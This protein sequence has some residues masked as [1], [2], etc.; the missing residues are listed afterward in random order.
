MKKFTQKLGKR[1]TA[2][3]LVLLM[4]ASSG[5]AAVFAEELAPTPTPVAQSEPAPETTGGDPALLN[6]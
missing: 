2:M 6:T 5:G 1:I 4:L 3:A